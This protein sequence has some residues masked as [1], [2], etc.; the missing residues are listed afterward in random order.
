MGK[1]R[2]EGRRLFIDPGSLSVAEFMFNRGLSD[3]EKVAA[4]LRHGT[5]CRWW[6]NEGSR[7]D[8]VMASITLSKS[9]D[10][11]SNPGRRAN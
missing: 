3:A 7:D 2:G 8:G 9:V 5:V 10:P 6:I 1:E 11:G 4:L